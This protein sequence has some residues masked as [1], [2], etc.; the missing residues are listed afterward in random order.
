ML[1]RKQNVPAEPAANPFAISRPARRSA[2]DEI[3]HVKPGVA[4][5]LPPPPPPVSVAG[6]KP[7]V[8][9][10]SRAHAVRPSGGPPSMRPP[11]L[12][13]NVGSRLPP[14]PMPREL[15]RS[16][17]VPPSFADF[18][19]APTSKAEPKLERPSGR[20]IT[21]APPSRRPRPRIDEVASDMIEPMAIT[22][23]PPAGARPSASWAMALLA[24]GVFG[25]VVT[26]IIA[27]GET[28]TVLRAGARFIDPDATRNARVVAAAERPVLAPAQPTAFTIPAAAPEPTVE[29][30]PAPARESA[31]AERVATSEH[32]S[33]K[34]EARPVRAIVGEPLNIE[35]KA[36]KRVETPSKGE[37]VSAKPEVK[38]AR[39]APRPRV[40]WA[41]PPRR[42]APVAKAKPKADK[43][44]D[45]A[46]KRRPSLDPSAAA[47]NA[48]AK[49][50]LEGTL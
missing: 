4:P 8:I 20:A 46:P 9:P 32:N 24:L 6:A 12:P 7:T 23:H 30:D 39:E 21:A 1:P 34:V 48:L 14:P 42:P 49:A 27:G 33:E 44:D 10:P 29:R 26:A 31:P 41:P 35:A 13:R 28:D 37:V 43:S 40:S 47:A 38:E 15:P 2:S 3:T 5:S 17:F 16:S 36:P 50:Q 25:G 22:H 45:E 11:P 18:E 19:H